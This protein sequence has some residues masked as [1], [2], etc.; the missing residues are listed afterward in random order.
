MR[1]KWCCLLVGMMVLTGCKPKLP[2]GI[3]SENK[4]EDV[5]VDYHLA[6]GMAESAY[7]D[8]EVLR[9]QYIQAVF[10][11][12]HI[13]EAVFDSSMVYYSA[14]AERLAAIYVNVQ[15]RIEAQ[16]SRMGVDA[17]SAHGQF[18][19]L[20]STGD[21]ANV[22][23]ERNY[24]CLLPNR[25]QNVYQFQLKA[26]STFHK[27]DHF[28][29]RF[30]TQLVSQATMSDVYAQLILDYQNDS[31]VSVTTPIRG[32]TMVELRYDC[33]PELDSVEV[34]R[35]RGFVY[36]SLPKEE[37]KMFQMLMLQD[38][39]LVKMHKMPSAPLI[40]AP[41]DTAAV[42]TLSRDTMPV[43]RQS[44]I[45]LSPAE[46]RD[47]QPVEHRINV[48]KENPHPIRRQN[49]MGI[50]TSRKNRR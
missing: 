48:V 49:N 3:L 40:P 22:W 42:D 37:D 10:R 1:N 27:G 30:Q 46:K 11:K 14:H 21:T 24:A 44:G 4:M 34:R 18:A 8:V 12:H 15:Q 9:Y 17:E 45:R 29:W 16:A 31:V 47:E 35:I 28:L 38:I 25:L 5:L 20:S 50:N 41:A 2:S 6:Q 39:S 23:V 43:P 33:A 32:S 7:K 13:S 36:M 19:N 26:D